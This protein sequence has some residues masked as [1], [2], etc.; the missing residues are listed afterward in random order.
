VNKFEKLQKKF[1]FL[2]HVTYANNEYVGIIQNYDKHCLSIYD[3]E[4]LK[5]IDEK[6]LFLDMG[7]VWWN[8][9]NRLIPINIFLKKDFAYFKI[10]LSTFIAKDCEVLAG[11]QISLKNISE[12]RVKKRSI[13]L[14]KKAN[15]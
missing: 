7:D 2:S 8:E 15:S 13:Q 5:T 12:K 3:I 10:C 11:P 6:K 14:V 1:P 4:R 9:S